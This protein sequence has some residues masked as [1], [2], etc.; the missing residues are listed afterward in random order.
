MA[1]A[2][3][4]NLISD[5]FG[6]GLGG[7]VERFSHKLGLPHPRIPHQLEHSFKVKSWKVSGQVVGLTIGCI[8]GLAPLLFL[9]HK[10]EE[11]G[12]EKKKKKKEKN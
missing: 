4:G 8:L 7:V 6:V 11:E 2:G 1:A 10:E 12:E 9:E 5:V 3:I